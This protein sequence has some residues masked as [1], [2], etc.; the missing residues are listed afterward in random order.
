T[1]V[2]N[3]KETKW[4]LSGFPVPLV[5]PNQQGNRQEKGVKFGIVHADG[6]V[7]ALIRN[8]S[9]A[10]AWSFDGAQWIEQASLLNG[11]ELDGKPILTASGDLAR[12]MRDRGVRLRDLDHDGRCELILAN[13]SQNAAFAWSE[14]EHSWK[15]LPYALPLETSI[16]DAEGADNG[17]RFVDINDDGY[18]DVLFSNEKEFALHLF[19]ATP[20]SWLGWERGWTFKVSGGK[21]VESGELPMIVRG[22]TNR[23][24]GVWF[25]AGQ[26][27]VQNEETAHRPDKVEHRSF[28]QLLTRD[29]SPPKSPEAPLGAIRVR[30]GFKGE[31]GASQPLSREPVAVDWGP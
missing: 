14:Q 19:I 4:V 1:R 13:E 25:K 23:N 11:L 16:V 3:P 9:V 24:N 12:G 30:S 27:W 17:L 7:T 8:E 5:E 21:R 28:A 15:R 22:G 10:Q 6:R 29:E 26:M 2:W 31:L 18:D 20:K